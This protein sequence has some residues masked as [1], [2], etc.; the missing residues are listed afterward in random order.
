MKTIFELEELDYCGGSSRYIAYFENQDDAKH[1]IGVQRYP[2]L[3]KVNPIKVFSSAEEFLGK[4]V[5]DAREK[6]LA[7]LSREDR[8]VL[9]L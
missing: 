1:V 4:Q 2:E 5:E 7:K 8:E 9:G 3:Y 6:A